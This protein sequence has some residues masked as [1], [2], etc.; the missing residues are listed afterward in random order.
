MLIMAENHVK[1][2]F[3][4]CWNKDNGYLQSIPVELSL[5]SDRCKHGGEPGISLL[6]LS[7]L[8][9]V[10]ITLCL[11]VRSISPFKPV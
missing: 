8:I 4:F 3:G 9:D 7:T 1:P 2:V 10:G 11:S 6:L 5:Q